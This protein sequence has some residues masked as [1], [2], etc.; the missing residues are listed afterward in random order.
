MEKGA[1]SSKNRKIERGAGS[2][3]NYQGARGKIK[4][5]REQRE[6]KKEQ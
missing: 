1:G 6:I 3:R 4:R 5:S 2:K